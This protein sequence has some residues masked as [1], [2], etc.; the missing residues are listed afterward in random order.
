MVVRAF[1]VAISADHLTLLDFSQD[2]TPRAYSPRLANREAFT[3]SMV[4]IHYIKWIGHT[5]VCTR[6]R[7]KFVY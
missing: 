3:F 2:L 5:A 7:F 1:T 4:K 6:L